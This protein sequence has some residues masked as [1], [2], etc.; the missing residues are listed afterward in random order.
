MRV[1]R[2]VRVTDRIGVD[3]FGL[4]ANQTSNM[5]RMMSGGEGR[6]PDVTT[7]V[8]LGIDFALAPR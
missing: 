5:R 4:M 7:V 2:I 1:G 6:D 8:Q 3:F